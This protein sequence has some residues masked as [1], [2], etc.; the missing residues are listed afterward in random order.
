MEPMETVGP[1]MH[2]PIWGVVLHFCERV[3]LPLSR[4]NVRQHNGIKAGNISS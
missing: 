2:V 1:P 4:G 3:Q